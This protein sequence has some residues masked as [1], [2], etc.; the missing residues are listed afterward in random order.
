MHLT[1]CKSRHTTFLSTMLLLIILVN[2][3]CLTFG[4]N[5]TNANSNAA[6]KCSEPCPAVRCKSPVTR[7]GLCC[8]ECPTGRRCFYK[9]RVY[10]NGQTFKDLCNTC[11]CNDGS[12]S[13]TEMACLPKAGKC[14][15]QDPD[16]PGICILGCMND[17]HCNGV[18]KCCSNGCGFVCMLPIGRLSTQR[19][20]PGVYCPEVYCD[21]QFIP[22]GGCCS[23]CPLTMPLT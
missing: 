13:C 4:Q 10:Q 19:H 17:W 18:Q 21:N 22:L 23:T 16:M 12:V 8:P 11:K 5:S 7:A 1:N 3:V 6:K 20:C 9:W 15:R 2:F 14:P